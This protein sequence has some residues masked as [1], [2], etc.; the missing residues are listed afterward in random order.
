MARQ[1][2]R[3]LVAGERLLDRY[4]I[5]DVIG[6]GGM[7]TIYRAH[8]DRLD[9]VVC[10]K[11]MK[12]L[13]EPGTGRD[14]L[15][16]A[17]YQHFEREALALSRL[18][19]PNTLRIF[20]YGYLPD[21]KQ[22]VQIS[23]YLDGGNLEDR[24]RSHG[25]L[26][27]EETMQ[28]L[29]PITSAIEEAHAHRIIHRDIKP[30]NILFGYVGHTT[31]AKLADFG[32]AHTD[33]RRPLA[34]AGVDE[35]SISTV[36][37]FSPRWAAPEQLCGMP[38]GPA[39]DVYSLA[40][41]TVY[42]LTGELVF[43]MKQ[44]QDTF[45]D[46]VYGDR[47]VL[48][49]LAALGLGDSEPLVSALRA[50]GAQ[51]MPTPRH[52]LD[53]LRRTPPVSRRLP[54][55]NPPPQRPPVAAPPRTE[56]PAPRTDLVIDEHSSR[57]EIVAP[58][59]LGTGRVYRLAEVSERLDLSFPA[60]ADSGVTSPVRFRVAFLPAT[61]AVHVKGLSCFVA[62][63]GGAISPALTVHDSCILQFVTPAKQPLGEVHLVFGAHGDAP[64]TCVFLVDG[65]QMVVPSDGG[66]ALYLPSGTDIV[67]MSH[68][69]RR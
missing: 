54:R 41:V 64:G 58:Q 9:R 51:R 2:L 8:D 17:T 33:I 21:G 67:V 47:V 14:K 50:D 6:R 4:T 20:D 22:P 46:R 36:A 18:Q 24:I 66:V 69:R 25:P 53:A 10:A 57:A 26:G 52:F 65:H 29:E 48:D 38:V 59:A 5:I 37:L 62:K 32:I 63:R 56:A 44:V 31:I 30:S 16:E 49:R 1:S 34:A 40:L 39:T 43:D 45:K 35:P 61:T 7:A 11:V 15:F 12:V 27:F 19:H 3:D 13:L 42:M 28:V 23:E 55:P 60:P 68:R